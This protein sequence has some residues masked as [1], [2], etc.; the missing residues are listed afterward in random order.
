MARQ[1]YNLNAAVFAVLR[2]GNS[3]LSLRR[4]GTGWLD[5]HWSL[6]AG[7]HDG[8]TSL[9]NSVLRELSEETGLSADATECRLLHVQ[10]VFN[11]D[12]VEWLGFYFGVD[13]FVGTPVVAEPDKHDALEWRDLTDDG[14]PTVP[15]VRTA[16]EHIAEGSNFSVY[17]D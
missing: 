8:H 6:P 7:A 16:L 3:V 5:G 13:A 10:Q 15:Y 12:G 11:P 14:D 9:A 17:R 4:S 1:R 2:N